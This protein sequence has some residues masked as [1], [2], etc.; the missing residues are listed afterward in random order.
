MIVNHT[1]CGMLTFKDAAL[2]DQLY[3]AT[4]AYSAIPA[5]FHAFENL[6]KNVREQIAK[7]KSHPWL[8]KR[9]R[10]VGFVYDVKNG[11]L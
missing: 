7:I 8:P 3:T 5:A 10:C 1:D 11:Q 4:H 6:E 2:K 9:F